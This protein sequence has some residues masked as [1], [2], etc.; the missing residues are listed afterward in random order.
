MPKSDKP[1]ETHSTSAT[2]HSCL[3]TEAMASMGANGSGSFPR[4]YPE[5]VV[6]EDVA[7]DTARIYDSKSP[8]LIQWYATDGLNDPVLHE[9]AR[10]RQHELD[11]RSG[12][13]CLSELTKA[14]L[15]NLERYRALHDALVFRANEFAAKSHGKTTAASLLNDWEYN[16]GF[17]RKPEPAQDH[18][19]H[20]F[21]RCLPFG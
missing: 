12:K 1:V 19:W 6:G 16:G 8:G 10:G 11:L 15:V 4:R 7:F 18:T 17:L 9:Y 5:S 21:F 14:E 3:H 2:P 20:Q 13:I